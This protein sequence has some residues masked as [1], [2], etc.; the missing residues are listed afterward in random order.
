MVDDDAD[1]SLRRRLERRLEDCFK[2]QQQGGEHAKIDVVELSGCGDSFEVY[3]VSDV[4]EGK[5]LI[6]RHG[7]VNQ[8]VGDLMQ[9]IH[10]LSIKK[11]KTPGE[12][13]HGT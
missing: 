1:G 13:S 7:L 6:E 12:M 8:A 4:F 2:K 11:T 3:V 9:E 10:A 5:R